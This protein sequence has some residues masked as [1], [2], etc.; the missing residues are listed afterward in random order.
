MA[1]DELEQVRAGPGI[2]LNVLRLCNPGSCTV[3]TVRYNAVIVAGPS[4][5]IDKRAV[6]TLLHKEAYARRDHRQFRFR[7][8]DP[9]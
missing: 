6:Q 7:Q 8:V 2:A 5:A 3:P 9:G 4:A 1:G